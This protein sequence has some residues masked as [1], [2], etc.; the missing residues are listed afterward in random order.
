VEVYYS[1]RD[2]RFKQDEMKWLIE[3]LPSLREGKWP[4][5]PEGAPNPNEMRA[6]RVYAH[7]PY[8]SPCQI[9][10]EVEIRLEAVGMDGILVKA[11]YCWGEPVD[12]LAKYFNTDKDNISKRI[13]RALRYISGWKRK[14]YLYY[15]WLKQVN[16]REKMNT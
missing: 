9:A 5:R 2:I 11:F 12:I 8:E 1:P 14:S 6:K 13:S 4:P 3:N 7:A 15:N 16:Y 10:A